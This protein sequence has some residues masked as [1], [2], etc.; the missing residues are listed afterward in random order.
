M[1]KDIFQNCNVSGQLINVYKSMFQFSK[2]IVNRQKQEIAD[3]LP[4]P[5]SNIT[6]KYLS[7]QNIDHRRT[8]RDFVQIKEN[9]NSKLAF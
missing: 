8:M 5:S 7:F 3:I 1:V 2:G 4:I 9:I 6:G